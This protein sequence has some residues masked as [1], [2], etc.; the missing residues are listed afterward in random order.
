MSIID[1]RD[2]LLEAGPGGRTNA[3]PCRARVL[4]TRAG[5]RALTGWRII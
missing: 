1:N 4:E 2:D 3:T 5:G